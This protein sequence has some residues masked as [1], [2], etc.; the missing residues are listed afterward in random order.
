MSHCRYSKESLSICLFVC[1]SVSLCL[2][3]CLSTFYR[4]ISYFSILSITI[5]VFISYLPLVYL[6]FI[7]LL[8]VQLYYGLVYL[9]AFLSSGP[10]ICLSC[11]LFIYL[12]YWSGLFNCLPLC[13]SVCLTTIATS[14]GVL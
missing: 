6:P 11:Q 14:P 12:L 9:C 7:D 2:F 4:F 8:A 13:L 5:S 1:V 3:V 10:S